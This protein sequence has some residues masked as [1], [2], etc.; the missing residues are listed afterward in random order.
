M[1]NEDDCTAIQYNE[2]VASTVI[3]GDRGVKIKSVIRD[4]YTF[5]GWSTDSNATTAQYQNGDVYNKNVDIDLYAVW[6]K[7]ATKNRLPGDVNGDGKVDS[8]DA[9]R[10]SKYLAKMDVEINLEN[11]DV[12]GD[13]RVD[14]RD[15]IR[16]KKYLAKMPVELV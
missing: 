3:G 13:G 12:T 10:L 2:L 14:T 15:L 7:D 11:A 8:R 5:I 9:I 1:M 6:Q 4:G 16:L